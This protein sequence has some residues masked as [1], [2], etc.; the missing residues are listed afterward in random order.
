MG[1]AD[2]GVTHDLRQLRRAA[3]DGRAHPRRR[4][5][6]QDREHLRG[7]GCVSGAERPHVLVTMKEQACGVPGELRRGGGD[8]GDSEGASS[9]GPRAV[10][11]QEPRC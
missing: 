9:A 2:E 4:V 8:R 6:R 10:V 11:A 3:R 5:L 7:D 1:V